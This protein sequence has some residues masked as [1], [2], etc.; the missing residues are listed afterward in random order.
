[1]HSVASRR[2]RRSGARLW[3][4]RDVSLHIPAGTVVGIVGATG[5][6]KTLMISRLARI[7]A[8]TE[9]RI[10]IDGKDIRTLPLADLR[11][12]IAYVMQSTFLFSLPLHVNVRMGNTAV[13]DEQL[14]QAIH[15][16]RVSNDLPQLPHGLDTMVGERGVMLSGGQK[17]R[18]AIARAIVRN[19]AILVLD[20]ALSSVD[21]QTA[22]DILTDLRQVLQT[23]T[24]L[25]VAHR[26]ATVKDADLIMVLTDGHLAEYGTHANLLAKNGLYTRMVERELSKGE[27]DESIEQAAV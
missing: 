11:R 10:L 3:L 26:I 9:G 6:G 25:I 23:R 17:Q 2:I 27:D 16:S 22:A 7:L 18:V 19:P 20:D 14:A 12:A 1:M 13:D 24:S 4:L 21:T 8:P 5:S 15:T